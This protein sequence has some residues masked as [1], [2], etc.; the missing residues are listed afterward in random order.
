MMI[1]RNHYYL[2]RV[3]RT[4][5]SDH[6]TSFKKS[7]LPVSVLLAKAWDMT[8]KYGYLIMVYVE[9]MRINGSFDFL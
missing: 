8:E 6:R 3:I 1:A 2:I 5:G 4:N 9:K 7:N